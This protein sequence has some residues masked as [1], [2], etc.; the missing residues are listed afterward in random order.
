MAVFNIGKLV[1]WEKRAIFAVMKRYTLVILAVLVLASTSC[2]KH[3][4]VVKSDAAQEY[5]AEKKKD[6]KK[7]E[8]TPRR[9]AIVREAH[10]W[11][12]VKYRYG[13]EDFD[14]TDCSGMVMKVY[15]AA[16]KIKIPRD[17]R[18]Q[19]DFCRRIEKKELLPGDLVFFSS[20]SG[21]GRISHVGIFIGGSR[22]IHS[23]SS[24]GVMISSLDEKYY[25][26]HY[27]GAGTIDG[28]EKRKSTVDPRPGDEEAEA[29][30]RAVRD[31]F[32]GD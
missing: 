7:K 19:Y 17:S 26:N 18:S 5:V 9:D 11:I 15:A 27:F 21:G 6:K 2:R 23:S 4:D 22:F 30:R 31:A 25:V 20:K 24:R 29:L 28:L 13:G 10:R 16:A 14:G 8:E 32:S 3:K 12:G 1:R